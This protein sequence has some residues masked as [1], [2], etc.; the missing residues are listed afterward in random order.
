[1]WRDCYN[2]GHCLG[3][4][5]VPKCD[6]FGQSLIQSDNHFDRDVHL[7]SCPKIRCLTYIQ[8]SHTNGH[9][10]NTPIFPCPLCNF[11]T[12]FRLRPACRSYNL[13]LI[14]A[15]ICRHVCTRLLA[16]GNT[17]RCVCSRR[18]AY[19]RRLADSRSRGRNHIRPHDL[20]FRHTSF[21][22]S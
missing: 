3:G 20:A 16:C 10:Q 12:R 2:L 7:N 13:Y 11:M 22:S 1:M 6:G 21:L 17:H 19:N 15:C 5:S 8:Y 9:T 18:S 14:A 4:G